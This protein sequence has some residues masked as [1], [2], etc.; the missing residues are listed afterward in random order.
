MSLTISL[1]S[2]PLGTGAYGEKDVP[3]EPGGV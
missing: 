3:G 2:V 1:S